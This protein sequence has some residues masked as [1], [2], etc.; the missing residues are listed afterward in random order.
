MEFQGVNFKAEISPDNPNKCLVEYTSH[1]EVATGVSFAFPDYIK[2]SFHIGDRLVL[3]TTMI[4]DYVEKEKELKVVLTEVILDCDDNIYL[5]NCALSNVKIIGDINI[6]ASV[7]RGSIYPNNYNARDIAL[8]SYITDTIINDS[9]INAKF[10]AINESDITN[11]TLKAYNLLVDNSNIAGGSIH[12]MQTAHMTNSNLKSCVLRRNFKVTNSELE[13]VAIDLYRNYLYALDSTIKFETLMNFN[14]DMSPHFTFTNA[15]IRY[16]EDIQ[17]GKSGEQF[18]R[19]EKDFLT[20]VNFIPSRTTSF[21]VTKCSSRT[22]KVYRSQID[23]RAVSSYEEFTAPNRLR[24]L[25][26]LVK[27]RLVSKVRAQVILNAYNYT[28]TFSKDWEQISLEEFK[29]TSSPWK[30]L[31]PNKMIRANYYQ[32]WLT[33]NEYK[34]LNKSKQNKY[35]WS[36]YLG[37]YILNSRAIYSITPDNGM[38]F[39]YTD[40]HQELEYWFEYKQFFFV[41][42]NL[43]T[44]SLNLTTGEDVYDDGD[45][46]DY[47]DDEEVGYLKAMN[48]GTYWRENWDRPN[49]N[50]D[51]IKL[52]SMDETY[53]EYTTFNGHILEVADYSDVIKSYHS[54]AKNKF[55]G[56]GDYFLGV[57]L[58]MEMEDYSKRNVVYKEL[59]RLIHTNKNFVLERDGSLNYG[60]EL[61]TQPHTY[62]KLLKTLK[63]VEEIPNVSA[64]SSRCG[65][66]V[67]ISRKAFKEEL[68]QGTLILICMHLQNYFKKFSERKSYN[69]CRLYLRGETFNDIHSWNK[70]F[71]NRSE[72]RMFINLT[73]S[74]TVEFRIFQGS[75][76]LPTIVANVQMVIILQKLVRNLLLE[77]G[78]DFNAQKTPENFERIKERVLKLDRTDLINIAESQDFSEFIEKNRKIKK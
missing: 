19:Y 24:L 23:I 55:V 13:N 4:K 65:M 28:D 76:H 31:D 43:V 35:V 38:L 74:Q 71:S 30:Y 47:E 49:P 5:E 53:P 33:D 45:E 44:N 78:I 73:N 63:V 61:I 48:N 17:F 51:G 37:V 59:H 52:F 27:H 72:R 56:V 8:N 42:Y 14:S 29:K 10:M 7:I 12:G 58:E 36:P 64:K 34:N 66:H 60:F 18:N 67:H 6:S 46:D 2:H 69:Y 32:R 11:V 62:E 41:P 26:I 25:K 3:P 1:G 21:A 20:M 39:E 15:T 22:Y 77:L 75:T 54:T 16:V 9:F 50:I 70:V 57:E 40:S 68:E